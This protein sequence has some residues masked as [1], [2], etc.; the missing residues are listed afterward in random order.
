[1]MKRIPK[2]I[3]HTVPTTLLFS[4]EGFPD[5]EWEKLLKL[6][7]KD[8]SFLLSLSSTAFAFMQTNDEDCL[9]YLTNVVSKFNGGGVFSL[10]FLDHFLCS[11]C[12]KI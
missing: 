6:Q 11:H 8:G 1:M 3:M 5:L 2:N 12:N 4:L 10:R 7:C 9:Q